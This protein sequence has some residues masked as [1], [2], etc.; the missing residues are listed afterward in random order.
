MFLINRRWNPSRSIV[1]SRILSNCRSLVE[2]G[3]GGSTLFAL[4]A[5]VA[6]IFSVECDHDWAD[7]V[8]RDARSSGYEGLRIASVNIG[9]TGKWGY[10]ST[11]VET[12]G[13]GGS[14]E[15]M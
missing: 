4:K 9:K 12:P 13:P 7:A 10:P 5:G 1:S 2:Y 8:L 15:N 11:G 14:A 6:E 3:C